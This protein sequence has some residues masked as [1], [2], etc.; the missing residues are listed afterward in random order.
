MK[1]ALLAGT[2]SGCGKTTLTLA[3]LQHFRQAQHNI[4]SFKA[5]PDFIDPLWHQAV[6]G[7]PSYNLDTRMMGADACRQ[8]LAQRSQLAEIA[9]I[10]G[11]MG[12]F[13]G[14]CGVGGEGS[15]V[16]LA[17]VLGCPVILVVDAGG[18]SGTIAAVVTGFC[19]LAEQKNVGISGV[20]ANKVGGA[21]HAELLRDALDAYNLPPLVAWMERGDKILAE[22]HL[23]L[24][25]PE[26]TMIPDYSSVLHVDSDAL[27]HAFSGLAY[28]APAFSSPQPRLQGKIIAVARDGACCFIYP[29]NLDWLTGQGA[30]LVFFSPAASE[31]VP[32]GVDAIWLPGGYPE[33]YAR[34]LSQSTTWHSMRTYADAGTPILAECGGAMLLGQSLVDVNGDNWPMAGVFPY[35]SIMQTRLAALGH[36]EEASGVKGHEFHYSTREQDEGLRPAFDVTQGDQGVRYKNARAS[37][38]HWYFASA[39][40]QAYTWFNADS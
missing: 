13:D 16:D 30:K 12:L 28:D 1:T 26:E 21:Y 20:I 17:H 27:L 15:S 24:K 23:G 5:G 34:Q 25:M 18:M 14:Y 40:N 39:P 6:T 35:I 33:L 36:R 19:Q 32:Q 4:A 7:K 11:V 29:A 31:P 9:L 22:R 8:E 38:V 3:L 37:Y 10:E 2:H